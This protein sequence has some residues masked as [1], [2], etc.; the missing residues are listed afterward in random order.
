MRIATL[1]MIVRARLIESLLPSMPLH[2]VFR[3]LRSIMEKEIVPGVTYATV[4]WILSLV[5]DSTIEARN[6]GRNDLAGCL[7]DIAGRLCDLLHG[8]DN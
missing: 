5:V 4:E 8:I 1:E 7:Y 3:S 2:T 6:I